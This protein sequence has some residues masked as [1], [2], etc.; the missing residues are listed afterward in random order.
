MHEEDRKDLPGS[1]WDPD[2]YG[3]FSAEREQPFWDLAGLL[4]A[5]KGASLVDLGCGDG[6]LTAALHR[7]IG[8]GRTLGVDSSPEMLSRAASAAGAEVSFTSGDIATWHGSGVDIVFSN[9]A[10]QWVGNHAAVLGR[11]RESLAA[12]G[13]LAVQVPSN[14]DHPSHLVLTE[15]ARERLGDNAPPDPVAANVLKP[16]EYSSLLY[17][18]GFK[19][20]QVRMQVYAHVLPDAAA[21]VEWMK[22]TSMNRVKELLVPHEYAEFVELYKARILERFGC[23]KPFFYPFKRILMWGSLR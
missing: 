14:W 17:Q 7:R 18:L 2:Q 23:R 4:E 1:P 12:G 19:R 16:E 9:A 8:A 22:G 21:L 13:Q 10:L 3:L 15:L 6:R 20:Q 5:G 11:W